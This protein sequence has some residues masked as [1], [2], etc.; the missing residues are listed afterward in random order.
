MLYRLKFSIYFDLDLIIAHYN[1]FIQTTKAALT[2]STVVEMQKKLLILISED[3][4]TIYATVVCHNVKLFGLTDRCKPC[5]SN[6]L[7]VLVQCREILV[8]LEATNAFLTEE[9][10]NKIFPYCHAAPPF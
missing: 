7:S 4:S 5:A 6:Q 9:L 10:K 1:L 2:C 8:N 3:I